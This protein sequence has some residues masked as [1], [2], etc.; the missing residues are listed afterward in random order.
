MV[1][2]ST[3][4]TSSLDSSFGVVSGAVSADCATASAAD[5]SSPSS[6]STAIGAPTGIFFA[7]SF[8]MILATTPSS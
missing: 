5:K 4:L 6:P 7:P 2:V 3:G 8:K 1:D